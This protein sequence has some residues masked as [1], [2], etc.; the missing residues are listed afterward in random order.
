MEGVSDK[1]PCFTRLRLLENILEDG[2]AD[3]GIECRER[4]LNDS[5]SRIS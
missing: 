2:F 4:V 3:M 1:N 5:S